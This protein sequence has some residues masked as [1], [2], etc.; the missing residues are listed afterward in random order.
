MADPGA[1]LLQIETIVEY[2]N[3]EYPNEEHLNDENSLDH[4]VDSREEEHGADL[5][6]TP[7]TYTRESIPELQ[8]GS[9]YRHYEN[10]GELFVI[11]TFCIAV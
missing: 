10:D 4:N 1:G 8:E 5:D 2:F 3:N 6:I 7:D 9:F 11:P